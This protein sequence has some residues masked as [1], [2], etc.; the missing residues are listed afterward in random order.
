MASTFLTRLRVSDKFVDAQGLS[1]LYRQRISTTQ[2][3]MLAVAGAGRARRGAR[4]RGRQAF[5]ELLGARLDDHG[6][7]GD[8]LFTDPGPKPSRTTPGGPPDDRLRY[9]LVSLVSVFLALAV[10][11][12]LGAGPLKD[13]ISEGL[14]QSGSSSCAR[15]GTRSATS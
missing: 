6:V 3:V 10:G 15:T 4:R 2:V 8:G 1:R 11:I 12:A 9:H 14:S 5:Y 7:L 13:P